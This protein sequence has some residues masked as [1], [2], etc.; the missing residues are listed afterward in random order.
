VGSSLQLR[1]DG[2]AQVWTSHE[3]LVL[4]NHRQVRLTF[5]L[6]RYHSAAVTTAGLMTNSSFPYLTMNE[7]EITGGYADGKPK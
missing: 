6:R 5:S 1:S 2:A 4:V 7:Y 3:K